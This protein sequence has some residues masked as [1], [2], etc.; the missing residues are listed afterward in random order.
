MSIPL[1]SYPMANGRN[2]QNPR[3][4]VSLACVDPATCGDTHPLTMQG[5]FSLYG[6][7]D[8]PRGFEYHDTR[9]CTAPRIQVLETLDEYWAQDFLRTFTDC[10][11]ASDFNTAAAASMNLLSVSSFAGSARQTTHTSYTGSFSYECCFFP[12]YYQVNVRGSER[13]TPYYNPLFS[14]CHD[15]NCFEEQNC[16]S[17]GAVNGLERV[18]PHSAQ[19]Y[20]LNSLAFM[21]DT[22]GKSSTFWNQHVVGNTH[23]T[24]S[25]A[26]ALGISLVGASEAAIASL[27]NLIGTHDKAASAL[28]RSC[29][30]GGGNDENLTQENQLFCPFSPM[31][32]AR[33]FNSMKSLGV[34]TPKYP[35]NAQYID[36]TLIASSTFWSLDPGNPTLRPSGFQSAN[37]IAL[38]EQLECC[39]RLDAGDPYITLTTFTS[40][41]QVVYPSGY[42][43]SGGGF[44][45][46]PVLFYNFSLSTISLKPCASY[47]CP[48]SPI[49]H[50]LLTNYCRNPASQTGRYCQRF[51]SWATSAATP[52]LGGLLGKFLPNPNVNPGT[53]TLPAGRLPSGAMNSG[54]DAAYFSLVGAC[55]SSL[56][57]GNTA[58]GF[59][60]D[61]CSPL[62]STTWQANFPRL[63]VFQY[64]DPYTTT[65]NVVYNYNL[66]AQD[67]QVDIV[68][69]YTAYSFT[70]NFTATNLIMDPNGN[71]NNLGVLRGYNYLCMPI[72]LTTTLASFN[73]LGPTEQINV[74]SQPNF[75]SELQTKFNTSLIS[76][77]GRL[78][79]PP[80]PTSSF[81]QVFEWLGP[82][83]QSP[84]GSAI[85][86]Q[87]V[88]VRPAYPDHS[89]D[90]IQW[91]PISN[92][93]RLI[94]TL[95]VV[96]T[97]SI[98][99]FKRQENIN[100][101]YSYSSLQ[102]KNNGASYTAYQ[103][104][105]MDQYTW[106]TNYC[107]TI[108]C[109]PVASQRGAQGIANSRFSAQLVSPPIAADTLFPTLSV[110]FSP[111]VLAYLN[112]QT[113]PTI[114][115]NVL[116]QNEGMSFGR[117]VYSHLYSSSVVSGP[118]LPG[119][120][121]P[122]QIQF[123]I[124]NTSHIPL[125]NLSYVN[126]DNDRF[127]VTLST[128]SLAPG[129]T[130]RVTVNMNKLN[131]V[132]NVDLVVT[133]VL[134]YDSVTWQ[135]A[136]DAPDLPVLGGFYIT[137]DFGLQQ[138]LGLTPYTNNRFSTFVVDSPLSSNGVSYRS[139]QNIYQ[140]GEQ[141]IL[142]SI[143][144]ITPLV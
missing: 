6:A 74:L 56:L 107:G 46:P 33:I 38:K 41:S 135:G 48:T 114:G 52:A 76:L 68:L 77:N 143:M 89:T 3:P 28:G 106:M 85:G 86:P 82:T 54:V 112:T 21:T 62:F 65:D 134:F 11:Q 96:D 98:A 63:K 12:S 10:L 15:F 13:S 133:P 79:Y 131:D 88:T 90:V 116:S 128:R 91:D 20:L 34:L 16:M 130:S 140:Q 129:A 8:P 119:I 30:L 24:A 55:S 124:T 2:V 59:Y 42:I 139:N 67:A 19:W 75:I 109:T 18:A 84:F 29:L 120:S 39:T 14:S 26:A 25:V 69:T 142:Y 70:D 132:Q 31:V 72:R 95:T 144:Q 122:T 32:G 110:V 4:G 5:P 78:N 92:Q 100:F 9:M 22:G 137:K 99:D 102:A 44:F 36:M 81:T 108:A 115:I 49:C 93:I 123:T 118:P 94:H 127:G 47:M 126:Y 136:L 35:G 1:F 53:P 87:S 51:F 104:S 61:L 50:N 113:N 58:S 105:S 57:A 121:I 125:T 83:N 7:S 117:G 23:T 17:Y 80:A 37:Q 43:P 103:N 45:G 40:I 27:T 71:P 138:G 141:A 97:P 66:T 111:K 64:G 73:M 101:L 60:K